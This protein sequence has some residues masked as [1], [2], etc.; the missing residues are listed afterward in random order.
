MT[1]AT[2]DLMD[3]DEQLQSC[4][5]Q[6]KN[7]GALVRFHGR[8]RTVRCHHDNALVRQILSV[9]GAGAVLVVDGGASLHSALVGDLMA[10]MAAKNH[11]AGVIVNGAIR[12]SAVLAGIPLGIKALGTNPRKS[13]KTGQGELDVPVEFG[14]A[15]FRPGEYLYSD[16]DGIVL[17]AIALAI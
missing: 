8:M 15:C 17:S 1:P 11:W 2:A 3:L 12:D 5:A 16:E 14:T 13:A 7:Y 10:A 6:L 9:E 4:E